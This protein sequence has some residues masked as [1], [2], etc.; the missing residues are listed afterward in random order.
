MRQ[1]VCSDILLPRSPRQV[2][3]EMSVRE[4]LDQ[5]HPVEVH[6]PSQLNDRLQLQQRNSQQV[7][8]ARWRV[9]AETSLCNN[10]QISSPSKASKARRVKS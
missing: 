10:A 5:L 6:W 4:L 2:K 3:P 7:L 8:D 9:E 1:I